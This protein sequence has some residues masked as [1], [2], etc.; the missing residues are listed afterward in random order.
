MVEALEQIADRMGWMILAILMIA[1]CVGWI[2]LQ[3]GAW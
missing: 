3:R 2:L 1:G